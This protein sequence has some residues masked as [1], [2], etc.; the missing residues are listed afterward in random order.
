MKKALIVL[1]IPWIFASLYAPVILNISVPK[2]G[3]WMLSKAVGLI[4]NKQAFIFPIALKDASRYYQLSLSELEQGLDE[5]IIRNSHLIFKPEYEAFFQN[6]NVKIFFIL[7]DPR[8]QLVS[9]AFYM[10]K[11]GSY[12]GSTFDKLLFALIGDDAES[13]VF[14]T[15]HFQDIPLSYQLSKKY[16]SHVK[17]FYEAFLPWLASS[18]CY[19]TTFE[20]LVGAAGGGTDR[21][22]LQELQNIAKHLEISL[23][24][25]QMQVIGWKIFG[26]S[27][28]FREGK[29]GSWKKYFT[30]EHKRAFK[31]VA[32]DLLIALGYEKDL[33]W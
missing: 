27:L 32:G 3:T 5:N 28:T 19:T 12:D 14:G 24:E 6:K 26:G 31:A 16:I 15:Y 20:K 30:E 22:Q 18:I 10:L 23:T 9:Q 4:A 17:R 8:D 21:A 1:L 33:H 13:P 29:I 7:R 2:S 25:E 11:N